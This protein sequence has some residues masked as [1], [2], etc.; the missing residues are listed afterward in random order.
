ELIVFALAERIELVIVAL[1]TADGQ[2]QKDRAGRV[3]AVDDVLGAK[4]LLIDA[5]LLV[6][7]R[8]AV[9]AG[10]DELLAVGL[11]QH[12]ASQLFDGELVEGQVAVQ[13]VDDPVA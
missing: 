3:D 1:G 10:G 12:I 2:T 5:A 4:L 8:V 13:S 7:E 9:E 6:E 11:R